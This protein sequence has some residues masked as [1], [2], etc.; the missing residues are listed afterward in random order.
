MRRWDNK[1]A[2]PA[3]RME[4]EANE[5]AS[6][7]LMPPP[8]WRRETAK[9]GDP[10]ISQVLQLTKTFDVSK[11]AAARNYAQYHDQPIAMVVTKDGRIDKIYRKIISFPA[12]CVRRGDPVPPSSTLFR[13]AV[14]TDHPTELAEVRSELWL[15]S[16]WGKRLPM[17]YEQVLFQKKGFALLMLWAETDT[18]EE[19]DDDRT[20]KQRFRDQQQKWYRQA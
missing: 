6:L 11:E 2:S 15:E 9:F 3:I 16:E 10:D 20:A 12:M 5:F 19:K 1:D 17:L 4:V 14:Q 13:V 18:E 8:L 7:I